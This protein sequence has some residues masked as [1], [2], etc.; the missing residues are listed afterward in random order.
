MQLLHLQEDRPNTSMT[1]FFPMRA[2]R[3]TKPPLVPS[4]EHPVIL[5]LPRGRQDLRNSLKSQHRV[6]GESRCKF[7]FTPTDSAR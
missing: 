5:H 1:T 4:S 6:L 2:N 7:L 3:F